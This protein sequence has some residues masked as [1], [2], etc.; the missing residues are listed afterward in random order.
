MSLDCCYQPELMSFEK[1]R[2]QLLEAAQRR[3][4]VIH[5]ALSEVAGL[6][7]A[8]E[9]SSPVN[10]PAFDNSAM[11]G[12]AVLLEDLKQSKQLKL[13]GKSFAGT[14]YDKKVNPGECVRIMTGAVVPDGANCVIKQEDTSEQ[15]VAQINDTIQ[16]NAIPEQPINIRKA[17]DDIIS[18]EVLFETGRRL[19]SSD[20]GLLASLGLTEVKVFAPLKIAVFSS[21]DEL[22]LPGTPLE[23]GQIYDSNRFTTS[24][25]LIQNGFEVLDLGILPDNPQIIE[26]A[27]SKASEEADVIITSGGV[28]VGEADYLKSIVERLGEL[29]LWKIA[30]K[31]GKPFA[32]GKINHCH[33]IGLPGNPVS[34]LVTLM[35]LGLPFLRKLQGQA[36]VS[37]QCFNAKLTHA[38]RKSPGR[39]DFQ[40]AVISP[41]ANCE[42]QATPL[43]KQNSGVLSSM[44][45][46][47]GFILLAAESG[48]VDAGESVPVQLF[49]DLE[50]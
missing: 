5:S 23:F 17:G 20:I 2:E 27:L 34:S 50:L 19:K 7:L 10:V 33:F 14:P 15:G 22:V 38:V 1:A 30:M 40:R 45:Q 49:R 16:F 41:N 42:W 43:A 46:A 8:S 29:S 37:P 31:P 36:V 44:S 11:D 32:Y 35:Q 6:T 4:K 39:M 3:S 21:G 13:V 48:P 25:L 26:E 24:A 12:Y 28:S 9:V 47:N 18:G